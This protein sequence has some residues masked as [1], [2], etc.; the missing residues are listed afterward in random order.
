MENDMI[1]PSPE[2]KESAAQFE[3]TTKLAFYSGVSAYEHLL[4]QRVMSQ[5]PRA[6]FDS[7]QHFRDV[8]YLL[9]LLDRERR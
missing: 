9:N 6:G 3:L 5:T 7:E 2:L 4:R 8:V 1:E